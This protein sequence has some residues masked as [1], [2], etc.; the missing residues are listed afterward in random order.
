[1]NHTIVDLTTLPLAQDARTAYHDHLTAQAQAEAEQTA[2]D[3][4]MA[5]SRTRNAV[6]AVFPGRAITDCPDHPLPGVVDVE[7]YLFT[8]MT[9]QGS[10]SSRWLRWVFKTESGWAQSEMFCTLTHFGELLSRWE[11]GEDI[12]DP[13]LHPTPTPPA[14]APPAPAPMTAGDALEAL[15]RRI[16]REE[17][18]V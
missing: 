1:M 3:R 5:I 6:E 9:T 13:E 4:A 17:M 18:G 7:G 8:T 2:A 11:A 14:E 10:R 15:I 16:V 12:R